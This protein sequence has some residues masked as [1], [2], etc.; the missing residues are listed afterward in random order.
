MGGGGLE[1]SLRG[2]PPTDPPPY[3]TCTPLAHPCDVASHSPSGPWDPPGWECHP[4]QWEPWGSHIAKELLGVPFPWSCGSMPC[5]DPL[6]Q[7]WGPPTAPQ[8]KDRG[9]GGSGFPLCRAGAG[10]H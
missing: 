4:P 9:M 2:V 8:V 6:G 5:P 10:G 3:Y 1:E 7:S